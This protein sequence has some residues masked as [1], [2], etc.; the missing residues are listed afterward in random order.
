MEETYCIASDIDVDINPRAEVHPASKIEKNKSKRKNPLIASL[1]SLI[2]PG[3]GQ[4]YAGDLF[5][6]LA[7][8]AALVVSLCLMALII[9]FL[10]FFGTWIFAVVDAYN[11]VKRQNDRIGWSP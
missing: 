2:I 5:R 6:G 7:F 9:G 8:I 1:L 3:L 10:T 4:V 11:M